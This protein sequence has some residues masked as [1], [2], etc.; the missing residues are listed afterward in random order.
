MDKD[1]FRFYPN[2]NIF[3]D[4]FDVFKSHP[5]GD[6]DVPSLYPESLRKVIVH[7]NPT[8]TNLGRVQSLGDYVKSTDEY[9]MI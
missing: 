5:H 3:A 1:I 9:D 2:F 8:I 6:N 7:G 4:A